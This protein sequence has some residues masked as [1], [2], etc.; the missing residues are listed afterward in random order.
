MNPPRVAANPP[1]ETS[2][3][4]ALSSDDMVAGT[5]HEMTIDQIAAESDAKLS[6]VNDAHAAHVASLQATID[7]LQAQVA[8]VGGGSGS[9]GG[10]SHASSSRAV[11]IKDR[12]GIK[13]K[14]TSGG[15]Q[16]WL[17]GAMPDTSESECADARRREVLK[18][19]LADSAAARKPSIKSSKTQKLKSAANLVTAT[20]KVQGASR[21]SYVPSWIRDAA[22]AMEDVTDKI[23]EALGGDEEEAPARPKGGFVG[24]RVNRGGGLKFVLLSFLKIAFYLIISVS[25]MMQLEPDWTAVDAAY[26]CMVVMSTVGYGDLSP[27]HTSSRIFVVFMIFIGVIFVFSSVAG[28]ITMIT[29][30]ITTR[31]RALLER[32]FPREGVDIEGDGEFDFYKPRPPAVYYT[33]NLLP[34]LLLTIILQLISS[35]IFCA[36]DPTWDFGSAVY[37]C[38]VTATTVGFGDVPNSTQ[39]GRLW[40]CFHILLSVALL[41]ELISTFDVLREER[42]VMQER[43]KMLTTRLTERMLDNLLDHAVTM[44]PLVARDGLGL[45]ELEF[46]LVMMIEL[47]VIEISQ[48]QPFIKQFRLLD[49]DGNAR[50]ARDD[51]E[52]S[53][54]KSLAELQIAAN[55]RLKL[56]RGMSVRAQHR[57]TC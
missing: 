35:A 16:G 36:I 49:V 55:A 3:V 51:L 20:N 56:S 33:K 42:R 21:K 30:P 17:A 38:I 9:H 32:A 48:I 52:G 47:K 15:L 54:N 19:F 25:V 5:F 57:A 45:T 31:G 1:V 2:I 27:T 7:Q 8:S 18:G 6:A 46:V 14:E 23:D 53:C 29:S 13:A 41:G 44:R 11:N 10:S 26:F 12:D 22:Q 43:I 24:F 37:H 39:A 40:A 28:V 50:L 34:S 4:Q